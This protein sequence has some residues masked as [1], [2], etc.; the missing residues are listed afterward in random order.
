[1]HSCTLFKKKYFGYEK[2]YII[3]KN[4]NNLIMYGSVQNYAAYI[5]IYKGATD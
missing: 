3:S 5:L 2:E 4:K 1:M